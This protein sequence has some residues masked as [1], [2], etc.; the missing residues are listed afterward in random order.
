MILLLGK[1]TQKRERQVREVVKRANEGYSP[2]L[3]DDDSSPL[4]AA[5]R[6]NCIIHASSLSI[7]GY[8]MVH[9]TTNY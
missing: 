5:K 1:G 9:T 7:V 3:F 8:H 6:V 4:L 2:G